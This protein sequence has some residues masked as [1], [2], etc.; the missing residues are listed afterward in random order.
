M[1]LRNAVMVSA[2]L[3]VS[4]QS[5]HAMRGSTGSDGGSGANREWSPWIVSGATAILS[6]PTGT[7]SNI[8]LMAQTCIAF[9]YGVADREYA[10]NFVREG[11]ERISCACITRFPA[12]PRSRI[13]ARLCAR[14]GDSRTQFS[15]FTRRVGQGLG[16]LN[17]AVPAVA[18]TLKEGPGAGLATLAQRFALVGI[19]M[20]GGRLTGDLAKTMLGLNGKKK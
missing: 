10:H 12:N 17:I 15:K 19:T 2:L 13:C 18:V 5:M 4:G 6:R 8:A 11:R 9:A 3:M 20:V 1:N 14:H 7:A 16:L